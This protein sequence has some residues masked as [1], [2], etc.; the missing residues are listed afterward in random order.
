M[1]SSSTST[2]TDTSF[3]DAITHTVDVSTTYDDD[4]DDD[5]DEED[6]EPDLEEPEDD[7]PATLVPC[8][9]S[10]ACDDDPPDASSPDPF[11]WPPFPD[12]C[13]LL[14]SPDAFFVF[15]KVTENV[16]LFPDSFSFPSILR[17]DT[18]PPVI[19]IS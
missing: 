10:E 11:V 17:S 5:E 16:S 2:V 18:V 7:A 1:S 3:E 9:E 4:E 19:D 6:D 14:L 13:A 12:D 15:A 8:E